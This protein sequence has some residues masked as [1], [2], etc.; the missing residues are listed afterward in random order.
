MR[1]LILNTAGM[2]PS[3]EDLVESLCRYLHLDDFG[4]VQN[5]I[6]TIGKERVKNQTM[7]SEGESNQLTKSEL[8][9][10]LKVPF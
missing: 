10:D 8:R 6:N 2:M 7:L 9:D 4:W 1:R 3:N 5:R